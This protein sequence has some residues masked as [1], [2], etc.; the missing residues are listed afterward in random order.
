[1]FKTY[2][3]SNLKQFH[4]LTH[5]EMEFELKLKGPFELKFPLMKHSN[6]INNVRKKQKLHLLLLLL[7]EKLNSIIPTKFQL[8]TS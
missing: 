2:S 4:W 5:D 1:M 3:I 7:K 6:N 8:G